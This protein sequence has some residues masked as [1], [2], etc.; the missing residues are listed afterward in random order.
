M[1]T[2][3]VYILF[4]LSFL[5]FL[6]LCKLF[7]KICFQ[8]GVNPDLQINE[9]DV[10]EQI[11]EIEHEYHKHLDEQIELKKRDSDLAE[12]EYNLIHNVHRNHAPEAGGYCPPATPR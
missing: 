12:K 4:A 9:E 1:N 3:E 7:L 5:L 8:N 10:I 2:E 11:E 6:A